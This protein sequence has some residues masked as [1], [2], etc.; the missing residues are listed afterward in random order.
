[1]KLVNFLTITFT[2]LAIL[3]TNLSAGANDYL[4][5]AEKMPEL[6]GGLANLYKNIDYPADAVKAGVQGKV[7]LMVFVNESGS[8]DEV[9]VIKG[10]GK[11][12]EE[13]AVKAVKKASF[14][15]GKAKGKD[16]KVKMAMAI[17]FKL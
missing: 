8:V 11:G 3:F 15:P 1:M 12:C 14:S 6:K 2:L 10:I 9:K 13:A 16:V 17:E 4:A 5:V 7:Y